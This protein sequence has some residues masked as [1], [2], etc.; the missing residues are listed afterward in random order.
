MDELDELNISNPRK[1]FG[2][3]YTF[4]KEHAPVMLIFLDE[5]VPIAYKKDIEAARKIQINYV[6]EE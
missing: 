6:E 3:G 5:L 1:T 4:H 2:L